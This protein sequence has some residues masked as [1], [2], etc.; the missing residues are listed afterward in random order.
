MSYTPTTWQTGDTITA[1]AL[2]NMESGIAGALAA[3]QGAANAG[4]IL[5]VG[6]DGIVTPVSLP[7]ASGM[8]F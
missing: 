5:V 8:N 4:N 7:S 1:E 2:N 3:N 6:N